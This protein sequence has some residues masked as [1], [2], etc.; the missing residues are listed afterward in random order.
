MDPP[1]HLCLGDD[2]CI[3]IHLAAC[4]Q[5]V[6]ESEACLALCAD[7]NYQRGLD[8]AREAVAAVEDQW[9]AEIDY[10]RDYAFDPSGGT[11]NPRIWLRDALAAIDAL[12]QEKK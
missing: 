6:R 12:R 7:R 8:A 4:E 5:R 2:P 3:C 1:H 10:D 9:D 11:R